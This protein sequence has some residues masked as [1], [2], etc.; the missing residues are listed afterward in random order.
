M[1]LHTAKGLEFPTVF[2]TGMEDGSFPHQR[3]FNDPS[4]M[5]EERRLAYVGLTRAQKRL[6]LTRAETR[7]MW[8]QPQYNPPSRFL[9]EIPDSLI[10]WENTGT[11]WAEALTA[12]AGGYGSGGFGSSYG[13]GYSGGSYGGEFT[14]GSSSFRSSS[15]A[16]RSSSR[17]ASK[18]PGTGFPNRIRP[19]REVIQVAA[20]DRVSHDS[21]GLGTVIEVKGSG[22]KTVAVVDFK[23]L[24]TKRLLMRYAPVEK[25]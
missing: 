5:S 7:S 6:I 21:F 11:L 15:A 3:S 9:S 22:D 1:T 24:G 13:G 19:N 4:E 10:E 16:G 18:S 2:L 20:G 17:S 8:G 14:G 12:A 23:S 25:L